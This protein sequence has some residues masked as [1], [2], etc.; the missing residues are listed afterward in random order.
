[1]LGPN[2]SPDDIDGRMYRWENCSGGLISGICGVKSEPHG[3]F[4]GMLLGDGYWL[5]L[6]TDWAV[7]YSGKNSALDQWIGICAPAG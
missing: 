5:H 3:P 7:S 1:M 4:G 6:E 2:Q